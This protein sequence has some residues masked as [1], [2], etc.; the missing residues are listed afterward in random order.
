V[1]VIATQIA[2]LIQFIP[3]IIRKFGSTQQA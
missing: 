3:L 2:A 1:F